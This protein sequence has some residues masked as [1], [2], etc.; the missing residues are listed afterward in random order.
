MPGPTALLANNRPDLSD[1]EPE[2][3][4]T[5]KQLET[6]LFGDEATFLDALQPVSELPDDQVR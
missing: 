3:D 4:E 1:S 5:E 6:L 2:K